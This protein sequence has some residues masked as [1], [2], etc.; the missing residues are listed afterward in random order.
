MG[1]FDWAHLMQQ[2]NSAMLSI[3]LY[4]SHLPPHVQESGWLGF[5][6][7][8]ATDIAAAETRIG[9]HLPPSYRTFLHYT[10][11]WIWMPNI[12]GALWS[13]DMI[14]WFDDSSQDVIDIW[15]QD[16]NRSALQYGQ[17]PLDGADKDYFVYGEE[18][19]YFLVCAEHLQTALAISYFGDA[20][21]LLNPHIVTSDGAWEAWLF[22]SWLPGAMR[23]PSFWDMMQGHYDWF[24]QT[25]HQ[26][27][28]ILG[29]D[30]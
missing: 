21:Y 3:P 19:D 13:S 6:G 25:R 18:Q 17:A 7:A 8:T 15:M 28:S 24:M 20:V 5:P 11:G 1:D 10:N 16:D 9:T 26:W 2:W 30:L 23:F 12:L 14:A 4:R 22:A 29:Y 27:C